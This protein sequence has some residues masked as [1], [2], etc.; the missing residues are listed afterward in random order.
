MS[1]DLLNL[2]PLRVINPRS[3]AMTG[4]VY[5]FE[6]EVAQTTCLKRKVKHEQLQA[7]PCKLKKGGKK[8]LS[9]IEGYVKPW[10]KTEKV[11]IKDLHEVFVVR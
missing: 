2:I 9:K 3:H 5:N 1:N 11:T 6:M 7:K 8:F 10:N 4:T